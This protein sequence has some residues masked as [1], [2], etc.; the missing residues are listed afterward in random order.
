M[1][2]ALRLLEPTLVDLAMR[3][4]AEIAAFDANPPADED[5]FYARSWETFLLTE[6]VMRR[7]DLQSKADALAAIDLIREEFETTLECAPLG[8][9]LLQALRGYI[10][11]V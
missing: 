11:Q 6:E 7:T 4:R 8:E 10:E 1:R 9:A 3:R 2:H 5:D